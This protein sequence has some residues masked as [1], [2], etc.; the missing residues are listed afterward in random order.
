MDDWEVLSG[1]D[2]EEFATENDWENPHIFHKNRE[3]AH[4]PLIGF[5]SEEEAIHGDRSTAPFYKS[6]NGD[7][8]FKWSKDPRSRPIDFWRRT[9]D[10]ASWD[11]IPVPSQWAFQG[12]D[13][14]Q[15]TNVQ[16][17]F[18]PNDPPHI[19]HEN[20]PVGSYRSVFTVPPE[21]DG[22]RI[23]IV[24]DGVMSAFYLWVNGSKIGYSQDSTCQAEFDITEHVRKSG[25]GN[26][27][28]VE[29]YRWCDGSYLEDQDTWRNA[30]IYRDVYLRCSPRPLCIADFWVDSS[31]DKLYTDATLRIEAKV[32]G[33]SVAFN[34]PH[35]LQAALYTLDGALVGHTMSKVV[36]PPAIGTSPSM[37]VEVTVVLTQVIPN[38]PKWSAEEPN[39]F[40]CTV[41]LISPTGQVLEVYRCNH[42][43]RAVELIN[44]QMLING[45]PIIIRGVNRPETDPSIGRAA[46]LEIMER[47]IKLMKQYNINAVRCS[48]YPS[49]PLWYELCDKYGLY[50][51]DEANIEAHANMGL[52]NDPDWGD[53]LM[54][55][56]MNM[57]ERDKNHAS[58]LV[59]SLGNEAG[60]GIHHHR[61]REWVRGR[62]PSRLVHYEQAGTDPCTDI[63]AI[64][65]ASPEYM[66]QLS[67]ENPERPVILCEYSHAMGNSNGNFFKYWDAVAEN[68]RCQGGFIWDW[69]DQGIL[70]YD[71]ETGLPYY[72]YGGDFGDKPND[73]NFCCNGV[74]SSNRTAHPGL[75]EVKYYYQPVLVVPATLMGTAMPMPVAS[76]SAASGAKKFAQGMTQSQAT[77]AMCTSDTVRVTN[78]NLFVSLANMA[79]LWDVLADGLVVQSGNIG[80]L[81]T[82]PGQFED[83]PIPV[84]KAQL[85]PAKEYHLQV[86][87]VLDKDEPLL[88]K[89]HE[90]AWYQ[91][92]YHPTPT[93]TPSMTSSLRVPRSITT[94]P[95]PTHTHTHT[96]THT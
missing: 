75:E 82:P 62:D 53:A 15:Y 32:R 38:P 64:M 42:G 39:L 11:T 93:S 19:P 67:N 8:K 61:M 84:D 56:C 51:W 31:L 12:Y 4:T 33:A 14:A 29:V 22:K 26:Q 28:A 41:S 27:M 65:Y 83:V 72:A 73:D 17:P 58:I 94:T 66:V 45:K 54:D 69:A 24:F 35:K 55:R 40:M 34:M 49:H 37:D 47:D 80:N 78:R 30:G 44:G 1:D 95:A 88:A 90:V 36:L 81:R 96:H 91:F 57:L 7:W 18:E 59:W 70:S 10:D 25:G 68:P 5:N 6:L 13:K 74:V 20:N 86:R 21:W 89:G 23:F 79:M 46:T 85:P 2:M 43:F 9:F 77:K 60:F 3:P 71:T 87:F 50:L 16:Q 76:S 92:G 48:H 63:I 52:T